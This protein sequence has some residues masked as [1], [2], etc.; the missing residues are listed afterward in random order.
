M[1]GQTQGMIPPFLAML[2]FFGLKVDLQLVFFRIN[3]G[4]RSG[5]CGCRKDTGRSGAALGSAAH[6]RALRA[7][8]GGFENRFTGSP[9]DSDSTGNQIHP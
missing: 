3:R 8:G 4:W 1:D 5:I 7:R 9:A 6:S 2:Y